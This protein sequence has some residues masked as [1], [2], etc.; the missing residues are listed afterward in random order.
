MKRRNFII[1]LLSV[2]LTPTKIL[3]PKKK[4][5]IVKDGWILRNEDI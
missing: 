1:I 2:F 3:L 4:K 5:Y